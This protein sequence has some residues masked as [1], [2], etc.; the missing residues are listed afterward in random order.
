[1]EPTKTGSV[2]EYFLL[3]LPTFRLKNARIFHPWIIHYMLISPV[4]HHFW[5]L[6]HHWTMS[7]PLGMETISP[8]STGSRCSCARCR[9]R[10]LATQLVS[11]FRY[12]QSSPI[13]QI[14]SCPCV[15]S[16][17]SNHLQSPPIIIS[18]IISYPNLGVTWCP[19][20]TSST[21]LPSAQIVTV[22]SAF[23][24]CLEWSPRR[25]SLFRSHHFGGLI[26]INC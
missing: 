8:L 18:I 25:L 12:L 7:P 3:H 15:S 17:I 5:C 4:Q 22:P 19:P 14:Q 2:V 20:C 10:R 16:N 1:M 23:C 13:N 24:K 11:F 6:N 26:Y 21:T 9:D